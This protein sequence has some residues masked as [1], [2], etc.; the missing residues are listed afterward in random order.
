MYCTKLN[1]ALSLIFSLTLV[2]AQHAG[3]QAGHLDPTFGNGGIVTT[4]F[5]D[6]NYTNNM[7]TA[8][9]VI[10][11]PNGQIVVGGGIPGN[12]D[13]PIPAVA[14]YNTNGSLDTTFGTNGITSIA[15]IEG[16]PIM[17]IAV[18]SDGKIVAVGENF[19]VRFL[20]TGVL[21]STFG[22]GGIAS[23]GNDFIGTS[24]QGVEIQPDGNILVADRYLLR[25][26]SNGQFDTS[27]GTGGTARTAGYP[28]T[29]LALLPSGKIL[30]A[31]SA[32]GASGFISQYDSNGSLDTTFGIGGQL[33]SPGTA[34]GLALLATGEF[35][36]GGSLTNNST[37][38]VGGVGSSGFAV[39][40]YLAAGVM[41]ASF[42]TN[43]GTFTVVPF[44]QSIATS[45]LA[46]QASGDIV[47]VGTAS[48]SP[49]T[50]FSLARYTPAGQLD[51]TFGNNGTVVTIF[52][53]GV[54]TP[55][56]GAN[57][58]AIQSDGK[59]V[60]AGNYSVFVPYHGV[61]TTFKIIRYL[62][63]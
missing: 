46:V 51:T 14:R 37:L 30:V 62:N 39:S 15:S 28:A 52:G 29:G 60:A 63:Q 2:A 55:S 5:G 13:F 57:A 18:Q 7:A 17:A 49:Q 32:L 54:Q 10:I 25:L 43:G 45:G 21:D 11:Q 16:V 34:A 59:I 44:Y 12:N 6:Q 42:G 20:S 8:N 47:T 22:T 19:V 38:P 48:H 31:S 53:G 9:A 41:D 23:L 61:D 35:L 56:I 4:D 40:R 3:A 1:R 50:A 36:V 26:L 27:F 24:P 58:L 33:A